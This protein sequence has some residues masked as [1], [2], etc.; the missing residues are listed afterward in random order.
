[1]AGR[2]SGK[3]FGSFGPYATA[4]ARWRSRILASTAEELTPAPF[5]CHITAG[6]AELLGRTLPRRG[7]A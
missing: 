3:G 6:R 2:R 1:M 5:S 7:R 4:A